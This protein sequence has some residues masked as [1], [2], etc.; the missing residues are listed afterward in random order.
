MPEAAFTTCIGGTGG[1]RQAEG[2][3]LQAQ[4]R[5]HEGTAV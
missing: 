1:S 4:Q 2:G 3:R 5:Y